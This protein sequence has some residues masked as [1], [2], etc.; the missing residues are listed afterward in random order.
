MLYIDETL[1]IHLSKY[2][3]F[4][5]VVSLFYHTPLKS[6]DPDFNPTMGIEDRLWTRG[7]FANQATIVDLHAIESR[8]CINMIDL[9]Q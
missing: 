2:D 3:K 1:E 9:C 6:Y 5:F 7:Q 8:R 4:N